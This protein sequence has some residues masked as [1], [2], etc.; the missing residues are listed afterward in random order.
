MSLRRGLHAPSIRSATKHVTPV[1][2]CCS[3]RW[4]HDPS[5]IVSVPL[6]R[7]NEH[8]IN[9]IFKCETSYLIDQFGVVLWP[10][11]WERKCQ[12]PP[13]KYFIVPKEKMHD[14]ISADDDVTYDGDSEVFVLNV[15]ANCKEPEL[16]AWFRA[17]MA[18]CDPAII[19]A[20]KDLQDTKAALN[21]LLDARAAYVRCCPIAWLV[22]PVANAHAAVQ[23]SARRGCVGSDR[24]GFRSSAGRAGNG[25]NG[26][27][28]AEA[29]GP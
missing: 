27:A 16:V 5:S 13:W 28:H 8:N 20:S 11:E 24:V 15:P 2:G 12:P 14:M 25:K 4:E 22:Y 26:S 7:L 17:G 23:P 9:R 29:Q 3:G 1:F 18:S 19:Q 6:F 21:R 10:Q